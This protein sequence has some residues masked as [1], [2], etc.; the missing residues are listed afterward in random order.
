M[1]RSPGGLTRLPQSALGLSDEYL[2]Q[3]AADVQTWD[4]AFSRPWE[5]NDEKFP[6]CL[7]PESLSLR[8]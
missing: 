4:T 5:F 1:P 6:A 7:N 3:R 2:R 8:I